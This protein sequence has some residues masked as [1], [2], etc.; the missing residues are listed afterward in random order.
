MEAWDNNTS[1]PVMIFECQGMLSALQREKGSSEGS[2]YARKSL[3]VATN[4][5]GCLSLFGMY[6]L[7]KAGRTFILF[8]CRDLI[9]TFRTANFLQFPYFS[10][11]K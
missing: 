4:V 9:Y 3:V 7:W 8:S 10:E 2:S 5:Y 6:E 11:E 1:Y